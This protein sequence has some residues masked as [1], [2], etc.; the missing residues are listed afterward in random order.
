MEKIMV[1]DLPGLFR[2]IAAMMA[3]KENEL[4]EM[5]SRLGDGDLGLTMKKGF[6][7]LPETASSLQNEDVGK[8]FMKCGMKLSSVIPSTMGFLMGSGLMSGG[9]KLA[10]KT[11]MDA[12]GYTDFLS[13][14]CEGIIKRGKCAPGERTILDAL[15]PAAESAAAYLSKNPNAVLTDVAEAAVQGAEQGVEATRAMVPVYGKAAVHKADAAG[16]PDQ[17]A[18]AGLYLIRAFKKYMGQE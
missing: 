4:C 9:K 12:Q 18:C 17:G 6:S 16:T 5:D 1:Q 10:G 2:E 13:G 15:H 8:V 14:F 3:E 7:A 11:E